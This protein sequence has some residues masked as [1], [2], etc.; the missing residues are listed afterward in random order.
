M[1]VKDTTIWVYSTSGRWEALGAETRRGV[2]AEDLQMAADTGGPSSAQF[3]LR[4]DGRRRWPDLSGF[5][6]VDIEVGG[7]RVWSGRLRETPSKDAD[8]AMTV[9][10]EGWQAHLDDD[11]YFPFYVRNDLG[12]FTDVRP[13]PTADL[14]LYLSGA[15]VATDRAITLSWP[16]DQPWPAG[17]SVAVCCDLGGAFAHRVVATVD[18][19][20]ASGVNQAAIAIVDFTGG[21]GSSTH[22]N[23]AQG[24]ISNAPT[25]SGTVASNLPGSRYVG[26]QM[27]NN[28]GTFTPTADVTIKIRTLQ[29]FA[30]TT[31]ESGG[32]SV[33]EAPTVIADALAFAPLLSADR[34]QIDP[35]NLIAFHLPAVAPGALRSPR[36][37]INQVNA[38]HNWEFK[39]DER[40]VPHFRERPTVP[41]VKLGA[42]SGFAADDAAGDATETVYD[43]VW[44]TWTAP[45][46]TA[47][48]IL[49]TGGAELDGF[50]RTHELQVQSTLPA[51]GIAAAALGDA[52]LAD[53]ARA[54]FKGTGTV[55]GPL[56]DVHSG[57]SVQPERLLLM[58]GEMLR[59]DDRTDPYTGA[60][61]RD[62]RM[63]AVTYTPASDTA[64]VTLDNTRGDYDALAARIDIATG[65]S[66]G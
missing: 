50:H 35:D 30:S 26:F 11:L 3:T 13:A 12:G 66:K 57:A 61:A 44:V 2:W 15:Q 52:W 33:L 8:V 9:T 37:M 46:G 38:Y 43:Q 31:Y 22:T 51:D 19:I 24:N 7:V 56:E 65:S 63:T 58:T 55:T 1:S 59:F 21:I 20:N 17:K 18:S 29:V 47:C 48:R 5:A 28:G 49:R 16:Q 25:A 41:R 32:A 10:C 23:Y 53:K 40:R 4:R 27:F 6:P 42:R 34:S 62:A 60:T 39:I 54:P 14:S 36:Q 64:V 45:D